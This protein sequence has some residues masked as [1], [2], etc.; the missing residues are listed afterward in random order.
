MPEPRATIGK[1]RRGDLRSVSKRRLSAQCRLASAPE[2][3][4]ESDR[5]ALSQAADTGGRDER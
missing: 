1:R 3:E 5:I 2:N 4:H